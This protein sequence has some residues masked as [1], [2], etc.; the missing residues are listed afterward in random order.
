MKKKEG[1][2]LF[3][4]TYPSPLGTLSLASDGKSLTGLWMDTQ[5]LP[6]AEYCARDDLSVFHQTK[7]WL[8]SY[9]LGNAPAP[10]KL[11]LSPAGT[12]FQQRVWQILQTI[13]YGETTTYGAIAKAISPTMSAQAAGGAVGRNPISIIIPCHR[14]VGRNGQLAG[15]AGGLENKAWLLRHEEETK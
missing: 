11:P 10:D 4:T 9:F 5:N 14:V 13:P 8:D 6:K 7:N 2:D 15:Y 12:A 3:F 1:S